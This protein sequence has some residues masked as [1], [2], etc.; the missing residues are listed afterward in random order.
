MSVGV[1]YGGTA[2][3]IVG[4]QLYSLSGSMKVKPGGITREPAIGPSGPT[5][6]FVEK[7]VAPEI[8]CELFDDP[9]SSVTA[10][11]ATTG[12]SV[13]LQMRNG[14]SW[15]LRNAFTMDAIEVDCA[16]GKF[17]LKMSG[18]TCQEITI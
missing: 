14:K 12:V 17:P 15:I 13:Q 7:I 8:E 6:N 18:T 4:G 9:A 16:A 1:S 10:L 5:G 11:Q 2:Q 3:F